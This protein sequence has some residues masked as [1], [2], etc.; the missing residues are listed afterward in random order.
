[1]LTLNTHISLTKLPL[2]VVVNSIEEFRAAL[3]FNDQGQL[4]LSIDPDMV[5]NITSMTP[6]QPNAT[7][8][9][10]QNQVEA[11]F[12]S[13]IPQLNEE[14]AANPIALP[15][16]GVSSPS[17]TYHDGYVQ[18]QFD[19]HDAAFDESLKYPLP[20]FPPNVIDFSGRQM[21]NEYVEAAIPVATNVAKIMW[22]SMHSENPEELLSYLTTGFPEDKETLSCPALSGFSSC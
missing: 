19:T 22:E 17:L 15:F 5:L 16:P 4:Y 12:A 18:M 20:A 9:Y 11:A 21:M 14:L 10:I 8:Q 1:M 3:L 7:K 2:K 13:F 6:P